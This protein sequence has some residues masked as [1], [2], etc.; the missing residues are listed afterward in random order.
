MVSELP[1]DA[2]VQMESYAQL[3]EPMLSQVEATGEDL[4]GDK[5]DGPEPF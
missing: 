5:N 1:E 3:M 2:A 4:V